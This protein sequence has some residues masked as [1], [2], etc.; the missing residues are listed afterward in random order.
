MFVDF[1]LASANPLSVGS[2]ATFNVQSLVGAT[3]QLSSHFVSGPGP[4]PGDATSEPFTLSLPA[5]YQI[6]LA[7]AYPAGTYNFA[8]ACTASGGAPTVTS[9]PVSV[10]WQ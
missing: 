9:P 5:L 8:A 6:Q 7:V 10:T 2:Y 3:C 4:D 1:S